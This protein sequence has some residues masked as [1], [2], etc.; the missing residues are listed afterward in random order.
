MLREVHCQSIPEKWVILLVLPGDDFINYKGFS[1]VKEFFTPDYKA[2]PSLLLKPDNR[3]TL[4]WRPNI[5]VNN[6]NPVIPVSFYNSDRTKKFKVVVE[7]MTT[8][9]KLISLEKIISPQ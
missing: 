5:F 8:S 7:G 1:I 3:I 9:G 6:I 2:D 4:L